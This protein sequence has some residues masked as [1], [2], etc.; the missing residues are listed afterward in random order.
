[1]NKPRIGGAF[2]RSLNKIILFIKKQFITN[3]KPFF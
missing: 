1:M 3:V 2:W